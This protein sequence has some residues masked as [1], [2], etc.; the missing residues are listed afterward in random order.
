MP[1]R[2]EGTRRSGTEQEDTEEVEKA[3]LT[4]LEAVVRSKRRSVKAAIADAAT[5]ALAVP[6][7]HTGAG[8]LEAVV[9][10]ITRRPHPTSTEMTEMHV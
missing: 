10:A 1:S 7:E 9:R 2:T 5:R 3:L 4:F 6:E 8:L